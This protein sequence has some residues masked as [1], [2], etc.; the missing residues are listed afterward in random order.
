VIVEPDP[1]SPGRRRAGDP[2][3]RSPIELAAVELVLAVLATCRRSVDP[4]V[5]SSLSSSCVSF[6]KNSRG[7]GS[8]HQRTSKGLKRRQAPFHIGLAVHQGT[9]E[10]HQRWVQLF[11]TKRQAGRLRSQPVKFSRQPPNRCLEARRRIGIR[12][13]ARFETQKGPERRWDAVSRRQTPS[14]R[15]T[16]TANTRQYMTRTRYGRLLQPA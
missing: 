14:F 9:P 2:S 10:T 13:L 8:E 12:V 15:P 11:G 4:V 1:P 3:I 5:G 7:N 6:A 16:I